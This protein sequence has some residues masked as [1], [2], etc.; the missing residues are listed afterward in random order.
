MFIKSKYQKTIRVGT[1]ETFFKKLSNFVWLLFS[2]GASLR[3]TI[4]P[5]VH[6][7]TRK[8]LL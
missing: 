5:E 2:S 4:E 3:A 7:I 8:P 1:F 6:T